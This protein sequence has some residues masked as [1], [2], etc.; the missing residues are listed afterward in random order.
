MEN[1]TLNLINDIINKWENL[2]KPTRLVMVRQNYCYNCKIYTDMSYLHADTFDGKYNFFC[3][4]VCDKCE[5]LVKKAK[6][7]YESKLNFICLSKSK[8]ILGKNFKFLNKNNSNLF[9]RKKVIVNDSYGDIIH[10]SNNRLVCKVCWKKNNNYNFKFILLANLIF[11]NRNILNY[12]YNENEI[13]NLDLRWVRK[14]KAEYNF[15]NEW[16]I[17]MLV[18]NR[19]KNPLLN[20]TIKVI[21]LYWN[22]LYK[23]Y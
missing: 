16:Y 19:L 9:L 8:F 22:S 15:A 3:W 12:Y 2:K 20:D 6:K 17:F 11:Y 7:L 13:G 5:N 1:F 18:L 10:L 21:F 14:L 4:T 23:V